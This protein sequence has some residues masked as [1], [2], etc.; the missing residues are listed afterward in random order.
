MPQENVIYERLQAKVKFFSRDKGFGFLKRNNKPDIFFGAEDLESA[1]ID[2]GHVN[3]NDVLEFDLVP[4]AGKPSKAKN[5]KY[6]SRAT[7]NAS[8]GRARRP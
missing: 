3:E 6:I 5:I 4:V 2:F 8:T 7:F 1:G